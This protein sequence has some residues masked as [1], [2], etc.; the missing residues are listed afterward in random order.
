M[1]KLKLFGSKVLLATSLLIASTALATATPILSFSSVDGASIAFTGADNSFQFMPGVGG[2]DFR[3]TLS[4]A[5]WPGGMN[6]LIGYLGDVNGS[7]TIANT[8][9]PAAV[10]GTGTLTLYN[11]T[12]TASVSGDLQWLSI[13]S[14]G[15][16]GTI[17]VG[18]TLNFFN[19]VLS[20]VDANLQKL[21]EAGGAKV[22]V[23]FQTLSGGGVL[24]PDGPEECTGLIGQ[25]RCDANTSASYSG[26]LESEVPEPSTILLSGVA[27]LALG[28]MR[29]RGSKR[30]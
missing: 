1:N 17:N 24:A 25:V 28:L 18:G 26:I 5:D 7:W 27:L 9:D 30:A 4:N 20:G 8:G 19:L 10:T 3:V 2:I 11:S 12:Q 14:A 23:T 6:S 29:K 16:G 22:A 21:A 15:V 13:G